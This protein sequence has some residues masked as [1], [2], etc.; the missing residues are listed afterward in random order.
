[1]DVIDFIMHKEKISKHEAIK[2][3]VQLIGGHSLNNQEQQ[4]TKQEVLTKMFAYFKNAIYNSK[5]AKKYLESRCLKWNSPL[6]PGA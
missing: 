2:K 6:G 4:L 5:P 1:M 3:A